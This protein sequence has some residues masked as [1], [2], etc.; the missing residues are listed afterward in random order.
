MKQ[1]CRYCVYCV[2]GDVAYCDKKE[3]VIGYES[4]KRVNQCKDFSFLEDD[5]LLENP[6]PYR[7]HKSHKT[8]NKSN[9]EIEQL[10]LNLEERK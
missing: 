6:R 10:K 9:E 2:Y 4:A 7:P 1:Y 5:A 3:K 8:I